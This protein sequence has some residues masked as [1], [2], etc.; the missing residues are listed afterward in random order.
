M[1][2][3]RRP[4]GDMYT[5]ILVPLDESKLAEHALPYAILLA[6]V[7]Q[8]RIELIRVMEPLPPALKGD[9]GCVHGSRF[10]A[11]RR[12]QAHGYLEGVA[13]TLREDGLAASAVVQKGS[14]ASSIVSAAEKEP[15]TL[16]ATATCGRSGIRRRVLGTVTDKVLRSTNSP[17]LI[18]PHRKQEVPMSAVRLNTVIVPLDGSY[19]AEQVLPHVVA[20]SKALALTVILV[21]V[22]PSDAFSLRSARYETFREQYSRAAEY[23]HK[24]KQTL[25]QRGVVCVKYLLLRGYPADCIL[26]TARKTPN[27]LVVMTTH[28][29][30]RIGRWMEGSITDRVVHGSRDPVLVIREEDR[31]IAGSWAASKTKESALDSASITSGTTLSYRDRLESGASCP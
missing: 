20:L 21:R 27:N 9:R 15:S 7:F 10:M 26:D 14:P 25:C 24:V 22:M 6:R 16:I 28:G 31:V 11:S 19:L 12:N 17:L 2:K 18:I 4:T 8:S 30:S 23:L 29:R 1:T 3:G 13:T 5:R